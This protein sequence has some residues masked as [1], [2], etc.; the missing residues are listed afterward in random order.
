MVS[1]DRELAIGAKR[2]AG[3][4]ASPGNSCVGTSAEIIAKVSNIGTTDAYGSESTTPWI[5][6]AVRRGLD[7]V[8]TDARRD[9]CDRPPF[10]W[11][12]RRRRG[13]AAPCRGFEMG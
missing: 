6:L 10:G 7:R 9:V 4:V 2:T 13:R 3:A 8:R 1:E 12:P 5:T 11:R